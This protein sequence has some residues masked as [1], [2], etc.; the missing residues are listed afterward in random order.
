LSGLVNEEIQ[1]GLL[2][3]QLPNGGVGHGGRKVEIV[4]KMT[5]CK[6]VGGHKHFWLFSFRHLLATVIR[7]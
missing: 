7:Y 6:R 1:F 4:K 2:A 3:L 5:T